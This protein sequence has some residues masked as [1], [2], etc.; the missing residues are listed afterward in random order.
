[1]FWIVLLENLINNELTPRLGEG[2]LA[3][4][5]LACPKELTR[6]VM[7][8]LEKPTGILTDAP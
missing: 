2:L 3:A 6:R 4:E 1:M 8:V 7:L 5:G